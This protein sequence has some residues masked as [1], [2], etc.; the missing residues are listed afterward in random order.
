MAQ[1]RTYVIDSDLADQR[2]LYLLI[3][4]VVTFLGADAGLILTAMANGPALPFGFL[5]GTLLITYLLRRTHHMGAAS[6][7]YVLGLIVTP[8]LLLRMQ[9]TQAQ[10]GI[11]LLF[12][13]PTALSV[14]V[15][16]TSI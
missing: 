16:P 6:W 14:L 12:F 11:Y 5:F 3:L 10:V 15:L 8:T 13:L 1:T 2:G 7:I 9:E 4:L